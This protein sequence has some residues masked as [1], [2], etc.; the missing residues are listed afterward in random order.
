M[1]II[2]NMFL[3]TECDFHGSIDITNPDKTKF[4]TF[5]LRKGN[6]NADCRGDFTEDYSHVLLR[7]CTVVSPYLE[8]VIN[9]AFT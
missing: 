4:K 2:A 5:D 3:F 6:D 9:T 7:N 8:K 1:Y